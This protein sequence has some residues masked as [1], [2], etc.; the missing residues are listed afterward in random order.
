[1]INVH[2]TEA[3]GALEERVKKY[4]FGIKGSIAL[5]LRSSNTTIGVF[6]SNRGTIS[7]VDAK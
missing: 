6:K 2:A 3:G 7:A 5:P 4:S 1:V